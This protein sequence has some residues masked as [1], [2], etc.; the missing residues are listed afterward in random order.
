MA[1]DLSLRKLNVEQRVQLV[2]CF[3][4]AYSIDKKELSFSFCPMKKGIKFPL[5]YRTDKACGRFVEIIHKDIMQKTAR[6]LSN[7][8]VISLMF[9][10]ATDF[11]IFENE[12]VYSRFVYNG[13]YKIL[14]VKIQ[15]V[16]ITHTAGVLE[17][18]ETS[19]DSLHDNLNWKEK[20]IATGSDGQM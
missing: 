12:I 7:A 3:Y 13:I 10:G 19:L 5:S 9:D 15:D 1:I 11:S 20:L 6:F 4:T 17:A 18:I 2:S 14:L 16:K 8:R